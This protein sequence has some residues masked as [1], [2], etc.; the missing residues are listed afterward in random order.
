[1]IAILICVLGLMVYSSMVVL[2]LG[3]GESVRVGCLVICLVCWVYD[4]A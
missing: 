4:A 3:V 2:V 1:M